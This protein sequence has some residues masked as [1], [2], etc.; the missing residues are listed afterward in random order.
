MYE[1]KVKLKFVFFFENMTKFLFFFYN[2]DVSVY[3]DI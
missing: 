1:H 3:L 2:N